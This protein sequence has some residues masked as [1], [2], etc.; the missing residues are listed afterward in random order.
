MGGAFPAD[1]QPTHRMIFIHCHGVEEAGNSPTNPMQV[2]AAE[3]IVGL[4]AGKNSTT[5]QTLI[6]F[7]YRAQVDLLT[8]RLKRF[9]KKDITVSTVDAA[10]GQEADLVIIPFFRANSSG[11]VGFT[12]DARR[13]NVAISR[14]RAGVVIIGHLATSLAASSSGFRTFLHDLKRQGGIYEYK[15]PDAKEYMRCM[16]NRDYDKIQEDTRTTA[17]EP[18]R[19]RDNSNRTRIFRQ[20]RHQEGSEVVRMK[21]EDTAAETRRQRSRFGQVSF[22]PVGNGTRLLAHPEDGLGNW[23]GSR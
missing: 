14:A 23:F 9:D 16:S 2:E 12:D 21:I 3:Y 18:K 15:A 11:K 1:G 13:L 19:R 17:Q 4:T 20:L 5:T 7:P 22:F 10:Q 8:S 6:L